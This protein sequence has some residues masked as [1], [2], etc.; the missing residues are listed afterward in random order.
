[1]KKLFETNDSFLLADDYMTQWN[2]LYDRTDSI[3]PLNYLERNR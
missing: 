2:Y 3:R 1:M